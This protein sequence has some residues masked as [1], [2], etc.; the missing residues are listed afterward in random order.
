M[1]SKALFSKAT[2]NWATPTDFYAKLNAEFN[3]TLD[4]CPLNAEHDALADNYQWG[5]R[6]FINPPYSN[7]RGFLE[8]GVSELAKGNAETLVYLVPARTDTKWFHD[9]V[10]GKA[11]I[12]FIKGRLKFGDSKNSAPFPSM[13]IIYKSAADLIASIEQQK[14][15]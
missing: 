4:P 7:I 2:D 8:K 15:K 11:E 14:E 1:V 10:Y 13:L 6:V 5:G 12:R 9:L 3:F